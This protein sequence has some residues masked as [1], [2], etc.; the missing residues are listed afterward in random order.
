MVGTRFLEL[1]MPESNNP[2]DSEL[3][4]LPEDRMLLEARIVRLRESSSVLAQIVQE[5]IEQ[6]SET[7]HDNAPYDAARHEKNIVGK[8]LHDFERI[9][10]SHAVIS[11]PVDPTEVMPGTRVK[12]QNGVKEQSLEVAGDYHERHD[13]EWIVLSRKTPLALQMLGRKVGDFIEYDGSIWTVSNISTSGAQSNNESLSSSESNADK[14]WLSKRML[15]VCGP[16]A[17]G[18]SA[19]VRDALNDGY[20]IFDTG[21]TLR[22]LHKNER[23]EITFREWV[24]DGERTAGNNF[25]DELLAKELRKLIAET[26]PSSGIIVVGNRSVSGI[27]Y[28]KGQ[29]DH[30]DS[31]V[32]YINAPKRMLFDRYKQREDAKNLTQKE[33]DEILEADMRM[34]LYQISGISDAKILNMDDLTIVSAKIRQFMDEWRPE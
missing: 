1:K 27:E 15:F 24:T 2:V 34:G 11:Y 10:S 12:I 8:Q 28:L 18:K 31:K 20:T 26:P 6:S 13:R 29:I 5:A 14:D 22:S 21:P 30:S 33:F 3:V 7:T 25:T 32:I 17:S 23:P 9:L 16:H 19:L 4:I